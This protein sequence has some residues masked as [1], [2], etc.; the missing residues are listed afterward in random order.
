MKTLVEYVWLDGARPEPNLRSKIK[1]LPSYPTTVEEIPAWGFDGS[2]TQQAEG[3]YSDCIL[4]PVRLYTHA[5]DLVPRFAPT[6]YVLCE[7]WEPNGS[8]HVSNTRR[9][10]I[11]DANIWFGFEQEYFIR[12]GYKE[13]VLGFEPPAIPEPQGKY[14][15]GVGAQMRGR[16]ISDEHLRRCL[17]YNIA[18]EGTNAE[19]ALGQ[20]EYQLFAK[21]ALRAADDL[22]MS[23][24]FLRKIAEESGGEIE[25]HPKP[26]NGWNG[27]GLHTNF[28]SDKMRSH[29]GT[30]YFNCL[31]AV[32]RD[33]KELHIENY[34]SD[35]HLRLTGQYETQDI[36]KFTW[37]ASD[38]GA[39]I[40]IPTSTAEKNRGYLEDRRPASHADPY[41]IVRVITDA[42]RIAESKSWFAKL[43]ESRV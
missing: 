39:S 12:G 38:R 30:E 43:T 3:K 41:R 31:Y 17:E 25:L 40:R 14:Y 8:P 26:M 21:G 6:V 16:Q 19:V 42:V 37:G 7:V 34:G 22:W 27:S 2:S 28:S 36:N 5:P 15:C 32:L 13:P 20:W 4:Q 9:P 24:Y 33:R 23:R 1:V 18:I 11:D 29:G 10:I 35:N